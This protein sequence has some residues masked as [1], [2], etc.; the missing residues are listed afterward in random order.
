MFVLCARLMMPRLWY[1]NSILIF[2]LNALLSRIFIWSAER[3]RRQIAGIWRKIVIAEK[4]TT[5]YCFWAGFGSYSIQQYRI[6]ER[7]LC[8]SVAKIRLNKVSFAFLSGDYYQCKEATKKN[9]SSPVTFCRFLIRYQIPK[10]SSDRVHIAF[11]SR[12]DW[13]SLWIRVSRRKYL[14]RSVHFT[15]NNFDFKVKKPAKNSLSVEW[16]SEDTFT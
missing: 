9:I 8:I 14:A 13:R 15:F 4:N 5:N 10:E 16:K 2:S 12:K 11:L 7:I 1:Q 6:Q 3:R